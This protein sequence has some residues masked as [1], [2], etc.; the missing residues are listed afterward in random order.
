[1]SAS[2]KQELKA[3]GAVENKSNQ[4]YR[5]TDSTVERFES[6]YESLANEGLKISK[7]D[8]VDKFL[9]VAMDQYEND[10]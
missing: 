4:T 7:S 10:D 5:L 3:L 6:L 2:L 1:M 9:N 8:L